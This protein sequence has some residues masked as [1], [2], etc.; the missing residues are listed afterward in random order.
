MRGKQVFQSLVVPPCRCWC[1]YSHTAKPN[2]VVIR[3]LT[4]ASLQRAVFEKPFWYYW[5]WLASDP[6]GW[7]Q[8]SEQQTGRPRVN[9]CTEVGE[10]W[11]GSFPSSIFFSFFL[12][13]VMQPA[14]AWVSSAVGMKWFTDKNWWSKT[15]EP[16]KKCSVCHFKLVCI[17]KKPRLHGLD[18]FTLLHLCFW[19]ALDTPSLCSGVCAVIASEQQR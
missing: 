12:F 9:F 10:G 16:P 1:H 14:S 11:F 8:S 7:E 19:G 6:S 2:K 3:L 5:F 15:D 17:S 13:F 18:T 4:E